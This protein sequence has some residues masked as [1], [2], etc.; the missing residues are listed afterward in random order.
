MIIHILKDEKTIGKA[1]A[2]IFAAQVNTKPDSVLGFATGSTPLPTYSGMVELCKEGA[3]DFS[4]TVTFNLDE[5]IGLDRSREQSYYKFMYD[6]LFSQINVDM[7][8]VHLPDGMAANADEE[9]KR[10][11][12]SIDAAGGIDLQIL[13]I[14]S[15]GHIAFNEPAESFADITHAVKLTENTINDNKRFFNNAGEV[16]KM[17]ISMG[18]GSIMRARK[19]VMIC[20][21]ANKAEAVYQMMHGEISGNNP[22][23]ALRMHHNVTIFLDEA[24]ASKL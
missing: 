20:T 6:N 23:S 10:Y 17:A 19:I 15:N 21:G 11:E 7:K 9:C 1:A 14:G 18:I 5:Y 16:P 22:A 2:G 24:A 12:A 13:G 3:V 4:K 8:N